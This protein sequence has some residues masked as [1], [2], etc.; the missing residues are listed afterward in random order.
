M[1]GKESDTSRGAVLRGAGSVSLAARSVRGAA[2]GNVALGAGSAGC[3][4]RQ[5]FVCSCVDFRTCSASS[6]VFTRIW[7]AVARGAAVAENTRT[8]RTT[9][10]KNLRADCMLLRRLEI[11]GVLTKPL[12]LSGVYFTRPTGSTGLTPSAARISNWKV[13]LPRPKLLLS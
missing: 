1:L 8:D 4:N 5:C 7:L 12:T 11:M 9:P 2:L 3:R 13:S 10:S 6:S